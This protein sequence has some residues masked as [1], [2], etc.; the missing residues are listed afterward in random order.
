MEIFNK[1][2]EYAQQAVG[3]RNFEVLDDDSHFTNEGEWRLHKQAVK[4]LRMAVE[5]CAKEFP[6]FGLIT[7]KGVTPPP[8]ITVDR[9][10]EQIDA[11]EQ[12]YG[13]GWSHE[14]DWYYKDFTSSTDLIDTLGFFRKMG[15]VYKRED[16]N[17]LSQAIH[18]RV[19]DVDFDVIFNPEQDAQRE[20]G[21]GR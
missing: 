10:I 11:L 1:A 20:E 12:K 17:P 9:V 15:V 16:R 5:N 4:V 13:V 19:S 7:D 18:L 14:G 8:A 2:R 3:D 6:R 21:R